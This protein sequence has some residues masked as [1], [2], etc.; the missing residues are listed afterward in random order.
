MVA[1][2]VIAPSA[3]PDAAPMAA[4]VPPPT[5]RWPGSYGLV[6]ADKPSANTSAVP[7]DARDAFLMSSTFQQEADLAN[8]IG[9][10]SWSL[11]A[12]TLGGGHPRR[13]G[14]GGGPCCG[15][16]EDCCSVARPP[17]REGCPA[18]RSAAPDP[19]RQ[20]ELLGRGAQPERQQ[21]GRRRLQGRDRGQHAASPDISKGIGA[22]GPWI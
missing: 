18:L 14:C 11:S 16:G 15:C 1:A 3:P 2:P 20:V 10:G 12:V 13:C 17:G 21:G 22:S 8:A 6:H 9:S 5:A 4:P 19:H 7:L